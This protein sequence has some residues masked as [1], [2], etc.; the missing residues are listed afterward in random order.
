MSARERDR[1][2]Q[3]HRSQEIDVSRRLPRS[4]KHRQR[5]RDTAGG[6]YSFD[7]TAVEKTTLIGASTYEIYR[8]EDPLAGSRVLVRSAVAINHLGVA[9]GVLFVW[10]ERAGTPIDGGSAGPDSAC[11]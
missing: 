6:A 1:A 2:R 5:P 11:D 10:L 8:F 9:P 4:G 7:P 3:L